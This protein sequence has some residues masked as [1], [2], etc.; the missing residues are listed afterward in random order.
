[1]VNDLDLGSKHNYEVFVNGLKLP[2]RLGCRA[3]ERKSWQVARLDLVFEVNLNCRASEIN[4]TVCYL[5]ASE[6]ASRHAAK[7]E[8]ILVE[9][10]LESLTTKLF[11]A[12]SACQTIASTLTKFV[13]PGCDGAGVKILRSRT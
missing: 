7:Q 2:I 9:D 4:Q 3:E 1:M 5:S 11:E 10:Y 12:F 8:W 6:L 13:V